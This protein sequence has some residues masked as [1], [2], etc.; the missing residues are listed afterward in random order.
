MESAQQQD[1]L[2]PIEDIEITLEEREHVLRQIDAAIERNRTPAGADPALMPAE[3]RGLFFP[4]IINLT[5]L[6]L[7]AAGVLLLFRYFELRKES[8]TLRRDSYLS[9]EATVIQTLKQ[10][11]ETRLAAKDREI[12]SIQE[13]LRQVDRER[14]SLQQNLEAEVSAK[15]RELN[16]Q[17]AEQLS[18]ERE[19]LLS[20]GTS[21][22]G[23][24]DRLRVL[25]NRQIDSIDRQ[26]EQ[27]RRELDRRLQDK[28]RELLDSERRGQEALEQAKRERELLEAELGKQQSEKIAAEQRLEELTVRV[29]EEELL[30]QRAS[31]A[32]RADE[33]ADERAA[34][35]ADERAAKLEAELEASRKEVEDLQGRMQA[36]VD[37][38]SS[39]KSRNAVLARQLQ[40]RVD[41]LN[42]RMQRQ[43][44]QLATAEGEI[45]RLR[46][47]ARELQAERDTLSVSL[48]TAR[49][50]RAQSLEQGRDE[51]LREVLTFLNF[52]SGSGESGAEVESELLALARRDPLFRAATREIQV[53]IAGGGERGELASP[54]VFLG[55]V[56]T[57]SAD[58]VVI[59]AMVGLDV[60]VGSVIQIR[61]ISELDR[62]ITIA[63]GTVQ[64]VR[65][66]KITATFKLTASAVQGPGARDPVYLAAQGS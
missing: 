10:Q 65:G 61:R 62:E 41:S 11:S 63:E 5:A 39:D 19:R 42:V 4:L 48:Q 36:I 13:E 60:K 33:R 14:L 49:T 31:A 26:I 16:R 44:A 54:F 8:I 34:E 66:S 7:V 55:I 58:R 12:I 37:A 2:E 28:Q 40:Q 9:A 56:S 3:K 24:I 52:L 30:S 20:L 50:A 45:K 1:P 46:A 22:A 23:I 18:R 59:E 43:S 25:E 21:E 15:E 38:S 27:H 47:D 35:R 29:R 6:L 64:Q 17:M 51:A 32:E 53:L 57:V